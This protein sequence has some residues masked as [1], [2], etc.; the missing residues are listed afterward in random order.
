MA[1]AVAAL[2]DPS[3]ATGKQYVGRII[4]VLNSQGVAEWVV[5][6]SDT[7]IR[8]GS[9]N[10]YVDDSSNILNAEANRYTMTV[11]VDALKYATEGELRNAVVSALQEIGYNASYVNITGAAGNAT[12]TGEAW[13]M[14]D[15]NMAFFN[16]I[17]NRKVTIS[18]DGEVVQTLP[19]G[20]ISTEIDM[21]DYDDNGGTGF[22]LQRAPGG[23]YTY[24]SYS[25][26][27]KASVRNDSMDIR[28][29]Y[30]DIT[31]NT[32][33]TVVK[34]DY[35]LAGNVTLTFTAAG[36][37]KI[38]VDGKDNFVTVDKNGSVN[39]NADKD[40]TVT[41]YTFPEDEV[42]AKAET[43]G[44]KEGKTELEDSLGSMTV[45]MDKGTI[46]LDLASTVDDW[47]DVA[48]KADTNLVELASALLNDG[49]KIIIACGNESTEL[50]GSVNVADITRVVGNVPD[51][52]ESKTVT[53][54]VTDANGKN[55]VDYTVTINIAKP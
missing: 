3:T 37:Y 45:D 17:V 28:T 29:G 54:T 13:S 25:D 34:E 31:D 44:V 5:F 27:M 41:D 8:T 52:G 6:D 48:G 21:S 4:A 49:Y 2:G 22:L 18:I 11:T 32:T 50:S 42:L 51:A 20:G 16:V 35:A 40:I 10:G 9:D 38:T 39:V 33:G 55:A 12:W 15:G 24:Y 14:T 30:V 23:T 19:V 53:V 46:T 7:A 1:E 26:D 47:S 43:V 36:S